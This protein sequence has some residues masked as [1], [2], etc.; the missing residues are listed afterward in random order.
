MLQKLVEELK[1]RGF[2]QKTQKAYLYHIKKFLQYNK[3][4]RE[5]ILHLINQ[6][7]S[8]QSIRLASA[9]I[10][11]YEQYVLNITSEHVPIPKKQSKIPDILTKMQ[12]QSLINATT[13]EKHKIIIEL[14]Y[15]SGL[16]LQEL[17]NLKYEHIDFENKT[18]TVK[19]GKGQKDRITICSQRV[20]NRLD[21]QG[22][23]YVL[24]GRKGTYS[25]KS[26]QRALELLG[27]KAHITQRV[28]PHILRHSFATHLL[29]NGTDIRYIQ[30]LLGHAR[31]E[32]TQMYTKVAKHTMKNIRNPLD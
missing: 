28:T 26:V 23:G 1:L 3:S 19:Q 4:K 7:K 18:L 25:Q 15:S 10:A 6:N 22:T 27:K 12:I 9:T 5:Y 31:L 2:S 21:T 14:L 29:E 20:L 32:T 8:P 13:N 30:A 11:F 16:R 24:K 17:I